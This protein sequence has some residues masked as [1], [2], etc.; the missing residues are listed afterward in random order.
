MG[1]RGRQLIISGTFYQAG[2]SYAAAR[3]AL[4]AAI[5]TIEIYLWTSEADYTYGGQ[6]YYNVVF[7]KLSLVPDAR[8]K[9]FHWNAGG[10]VTVDF[11]CYGRCLI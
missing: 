11:I 4:Q 6:T 8:G 1:T 2:V 9:F 7:D 5:D 10:Y 3:A